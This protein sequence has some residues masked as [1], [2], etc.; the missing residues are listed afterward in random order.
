MAKEEQLYQASNKLKQTNQVPGIRALRDHVIVRDMN[1]TGRQLSSG[2]I[3]LGDDG[4]TEGIRP[5]WAKVYKVGPEQK[6][7]QPGQWV[8]IEHG[9]WSRGLEVE[10]DGETFTVRR[11]DPKC[12]IFVS[13]EEPDADDTIS[14]AVHGERKTREVYE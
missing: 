4:K 1:F 12:I 11:A 3:L 5:R 6:E 7:V 10:I 9:R 13:D 14:T 2:V 8:F